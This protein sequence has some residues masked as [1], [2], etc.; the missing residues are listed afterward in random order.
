MLWTPLGIVTL[1]PFILNVTGVG[2]LTEYHAYSLVTPGLAFL[3]KINMIN[4]IVL[5]SSRDLDM[6]RYVCF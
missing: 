6:K 3:V 1:V 2:S 4:F 5:T